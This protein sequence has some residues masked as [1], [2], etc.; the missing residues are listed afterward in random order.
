MIIIPNN[1]R[2]LFIVT[3][4]VDDATGTY[5]TKAID[6]RGRTVISG[7]DMIAAVDNFDSRNNIWYEDNVLR[8]RSNG[9]YGLVNFDGDEVI[10]PQYDRITALRGTTSNFIVE[11]DG[12]VRTCK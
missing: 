3:Y 11:N 2:S 6:E 8:V 10:A 9:G 4:D 5:R 1:S 12:K 7:F